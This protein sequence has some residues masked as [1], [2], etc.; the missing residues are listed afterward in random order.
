V[1]RYQV[2]LAYDGTDFYGSQRQAESRTVQGVFETA[3]G[4]L[5]WSGPSVIFAGRTD[6]GVHASGQ[7]VSFDLEWK[8][9]P[10]DLLRALNA[11]LPKDT[12]VLS[13]SQTR[14]DFHPRF[15][16]VARTYC[17]RIACK[18][19]RDPL[20]ERYVW[21]IWPSPD[22]NR[23]QTAAGYFLGRHNFRAYGSP[24]RPG[25]GTVRTVSC[26]QWQ[27][28]GFELTYM[29][30]A[31][32]FLYHMVRRLVQVQIDA[33][34]GKLELDVI[35]QHLHEPDSIPLQGLAPPVGLSLVE[36]SYQSSSEN[37]GKSEK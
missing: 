29:I 19:V 32:A 23:L 21:R 13:I 8:H 14:L 12:A 5:G 15:D 2:I 25:G 16:A 20:M 9:L 17:Y 31:D 4:K 1:E 27:W 10:D 37:T 33:G 6:A 34:Q 11:L 3:L 36:V 22:F 7:V 35:R 24:T 26:S 18:P 30:T 28:D